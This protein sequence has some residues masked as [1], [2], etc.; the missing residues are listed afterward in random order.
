MGKN[1]I[2]KGADFAQ[3]CIEAKGYSGRAYLVITGINIVH[4]AETFGRFVGS[5]YG[6]LTNRLSVFRNDNLSLLYVP[7]GATITLTGVAGLLFD[8]AVYN[9]QHN[10][11]DFRMI[12]NSKVMQ[13]GVE[14]TISNHQP[15]HP[16]MVGTHDG[17]NYF[18]LTD[19]VVDTVTVAADSSVD[20]YFIFM[21]K[22]T[23]NS[24]I[25][26]GEF[27]IDFEVNV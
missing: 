27:I 23:D 7:K 26:A 20:R 5:E 22:K 8:Y 24:V 12:S 25:T 11:L 18:T 21:A 17:T 9:Q 6:M 13:Y 14:T 1:L 15:V 10:P 16:Y 3:N 19:G 2:I 4:N